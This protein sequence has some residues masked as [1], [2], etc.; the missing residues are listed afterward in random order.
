MYTFTK[1]S[2]LCETPQAAV[3]CLFCLINY[4]KLCGLE[5]P[6]YFASNMEGQ[7]FGSLAGWCI[8]DHMALAG[9]AGM[10]GLLPCWL[11]TAKAWP[12]SVSFSLSPWCLALWDLCMAWASHSLVFSGWSCLL[13]GCWLPI[14]RKQN[15]SGQYN[16]SWHSVTSSIFYWSEKSHC[17]SGPLPR[18]K[19]VE[20]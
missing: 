6:F 5:P 18:F 8:S 9:A 17:S 3:G 15:L 7:E 14:G 13:N 4:L 2:C 19:D 10:D 1:P 12:L 20:K 11:L 16:Q